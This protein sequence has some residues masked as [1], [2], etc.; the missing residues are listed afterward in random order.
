MI[1]VKTVLKG[2]R[3]DSEGMRVSEQ[4]AETLAAFLEQVAKKVTAEAQGYA[5]TAGR[6]TIMPRDVQNAIEKLVV[7]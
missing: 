1:Y 3:D 2:M 7:K 6:K 5:C 4:S